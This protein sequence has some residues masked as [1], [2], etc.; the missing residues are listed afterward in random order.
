MKAALCGDVDDWSIVGQALR[1][2]FFSSATDAF[3]LQFGNMTKLVISGAAN[4]LEEL[5]PKPAE[6]SAAPVDFINASPFRQRA[7]DRDP[8]RDAILAGVAIAFLTF[9]GSI[10]IAVLL[11]HAPTR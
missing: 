1:L 7:K 6:S 5:E 10:M 11:M 4:E 8:T 2:P 9:L 3:A